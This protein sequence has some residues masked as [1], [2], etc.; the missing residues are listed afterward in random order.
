MT[1]SS[2]QIHSSKMITNATEGRFSS[3]SGGDL[4]PQDGISDYSTFKLKCSP[5]PHGLNMCFLAS[6]GFSEERLDHQSV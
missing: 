1:V 2:H 4:S 6:S 3:P 5:Q